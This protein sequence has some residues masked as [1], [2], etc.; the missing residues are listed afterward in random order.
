MIPPIGLE[1][2]PLV[3]GAAPRGHTMASGAAVGAF[4]RGGPPAARAQKTHWLQETSPMSKGG[5]NAAH[6]KPRTAQ[7]M[8]RV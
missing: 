4:S 5:P 2:K 1:V 8:T 6:K 7:Q 3:I